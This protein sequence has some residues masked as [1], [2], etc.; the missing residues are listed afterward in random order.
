[1][2]N[3]QLKPIL[4]SKQSADRTL[5]SRVSI[6]VPSLEY[7]HDFINYIPPSKSYEMQASPE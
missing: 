3:S 2:I 4:S 5:K 7:V 6:L 1:M